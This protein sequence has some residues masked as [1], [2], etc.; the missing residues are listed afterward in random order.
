MTKLPDLNV[1]RLDE[2]WYDAAVVYFGGKTRVTLVK[3]ADGTVASR[4]HMNIATTWGLNDRDRRAWCRMHGV[5]FADLKASMKAEREREAKRDREITLASI[6]RQ[7]AK[8]GYKLTRQ[9]AKAIP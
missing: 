8:L 7:A 5:R 2:G 6:K 3:L 9:R 4:Y 1:P